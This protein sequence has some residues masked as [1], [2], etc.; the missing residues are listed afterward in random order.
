MKLIVTYCNRGLN[1]IQWNLKADLQHF[2]KSIIGNGDNAVIM[3][4]NTW[5]SINKTCF[6]KRTNI[7]LTR[8]NVHKHFK[9]TQQNKKTL[10]IY[11]NSFEETIK[12]CKSKNFENT[13]I[14][15][16]PGI[17]DYALSHN[18]IKE[19]H[20]IFANEEKRRSMFLH[21]LP[22]HFKLTQETNYQRGDNLLYK[23]MVYENLSYKS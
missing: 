21:T 6:P 14:I 9:E 2:N 1:K 12:Y 17:Y 11:L 4:R 3:G 8:K 15:G 18:I 7:I 5:N 13:W 20:V 23:H 16:G 19:T 22:F 10:R